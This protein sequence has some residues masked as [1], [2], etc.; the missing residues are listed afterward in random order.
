MT[1]RDDEECPPLPEGADVRFL[2]PDL[3]ILSL[4]LPQIQP[5]ATLTLTERAV[6]LLVCEGL[7][8]EDIA[9]ARGV[10]TKTIGNQLESI[11]R[12]LGVSSRYE[13]VLALR[14]RGHSDC[15][16]KLLPV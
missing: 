5:P 7:S 16:S 4:P 3:A 11:Y 13:L 8:N 10:S 6:A 9:R 14:E 1:T 15:A 2:A 12:K